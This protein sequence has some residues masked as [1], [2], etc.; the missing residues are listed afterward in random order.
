MQAFKYSDEILVAILFLG[1]YRFTIQ[2][3]LEAFR[4]GSCKAK[5]LLYVILHFPLTFN[6]LIVVINK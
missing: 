5:S 6:Y 3:P 4:F 2:F 1:Y